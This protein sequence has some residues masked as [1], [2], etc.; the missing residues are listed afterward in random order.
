GTDDTCGSGTD[1]P[2]S[3]AAGAAACTSIATNAVDSATERARDGRALAMERIAGPL[4]IRTGWSV[5]GRGDSARWL[6][7]GGWGELNRRRGLGLVG[8][9]F[10]D[11]ADEAFDGLA[12][13]VGEGGVEVFAVDFAA[14]DGGARD[15]VG[16]CGPDPA[17]GGYLG[18]AFTGGIEG[19]E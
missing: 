15:A 16:G 4:R 7:V 2:P 17:E 12:F 9:C 14:V 18:F 13:A 10:E 19:G 3:A 1:G 6:L 5:V 8:D 11:V